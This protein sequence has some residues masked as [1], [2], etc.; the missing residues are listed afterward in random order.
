LALTAGTAPTAAAVADAVWD[1]AIA[2]HTASGSTGEAL[3]NAATSAGSGADTVTLTI[4]DDGSTA[5]ADADVWIT[6]DEGGTSFVAGTSQTNSA[7]KV[8]FQLDAGVTYYCWRQKDGINFDNPQ[9][10]VAVA[11]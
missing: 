2:D 11:D 5:I 6:S 10:F 3:S 8:S 4:E 9:S 1:E 7:G